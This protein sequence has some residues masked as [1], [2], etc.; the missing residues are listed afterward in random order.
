MEDVGD[1]DTLNG[2]EE[3]WRQDRSTLHHSTPE[4][5]GV[6]VDLDLDVKGGRRRER[7]GSKKKRETK[8]EIL[9]GEG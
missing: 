3:E 1:A 2:R 9:Y 4:K 7:E 5:R 6:G 8:R